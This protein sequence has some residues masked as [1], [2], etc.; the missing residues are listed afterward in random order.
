M[1]FDGI[2]TVFSRTDRVQLHRFHGNQWVKAPGASDFF[3]LYVI[4][5]NI[6][7]TYDRLRGI[8]V[9]EKTYLPTLQIRNLSKRD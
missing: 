6:A 1:H 9:N 5:Y 4:F 7:K 3:P 8:N 2:Q